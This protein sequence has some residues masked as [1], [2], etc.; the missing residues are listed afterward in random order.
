VSSAPTADPDAPP[1]EQRDFCPRCGTAYDDL[2]EYCLECGGR[3]PVNRGLTGVLASGWQRRLPWYPGDWIWPVLLFAVVAAAAAA[4]AIALGSDGSGGEGVIAATSNRVTVGPAASGGTT[5]TATVPTASLPTAPEP[6]VPETTP[7]RPRA[8]PGALIAWP[9][10]KSGYT[11]VLESIPTTGSRALAVQR[12]R[13]AKAAGL[14][15]VGVLTSSN[16]SSLHPGYY[17]VFSGVYGSSAEAASAVSTARNHGF[18]DAY[19]T[20]VTR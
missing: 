12:A 1:Q 7:S 13:R 15:Q 11:V 16:F 20:R 10:G 14:S 3:L 5:P 8:R 19:Q 4:V 9:S 18:G 6:T 2:Q 17:V